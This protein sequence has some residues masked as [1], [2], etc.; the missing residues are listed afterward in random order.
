M[1]NTLFKEEPFHKFMLKHN[2]KNYLP[3][4][5]KTLNISFQ[6]NTT[7]TDLIMCDYF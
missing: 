2:I 3:Q 6:W 7:I 5:T 4:F 1:S